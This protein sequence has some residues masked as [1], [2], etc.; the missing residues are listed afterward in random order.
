MADEVFPTGDTVAHSK[1]LQRSPEVDLEVWKHFAAMGG[2][3][4]NTMITTVSWLLPIAA[5]AI[6]S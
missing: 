1:L 4:K 3:D 5:T 6:G 2:T